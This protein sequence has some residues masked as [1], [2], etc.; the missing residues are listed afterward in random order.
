MTMQAARAGVRV[1]P[2]LAV[3]EY[4]LGG[5]IL[6]QEWIDGRP[7]VPA[8]DAQRATGGSSQLVD[9]VRAEVAKLHCVRLAHR[10]LSGDH[11]LIDGEGDV[12]VIG[13]ADAVTSASNADL[14]ADIA[15]VVAVTAALVG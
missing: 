10:G 15:D 6:V 7:L 5:G 1:A 9:K 8:N 14:S 3:G 13:F 12:Y 2:V 4:R 11:L